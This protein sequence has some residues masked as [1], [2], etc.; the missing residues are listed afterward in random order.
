MPTCTEERKLSG[1]AFNDNAIKAPF[2]PLLLSASSL[3]FFAD[4]IA[5]SD[6]AKKP[7]VSIS[8][9]MMIISNHILYINV[10]IGV[11]PQR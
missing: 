8:R 2:L 11:L 6:K 4:T 1:S 10:C 3:F 7:F 5:I 9:R